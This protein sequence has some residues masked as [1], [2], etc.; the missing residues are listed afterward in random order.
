MLKVGIDAISFYTSHHYLELKTLAEERG[1]DPNKYLTGL[2][3]HKMAIAAP[4]EDIVTLAAN[5]AEAIV[6]KANIAQ[7][8]MVLFATESGIDQS[9]AAGL[10]IHKLLDLSPHCRV[11][12]LK[13][14]CYSGTAGLQLGLGYLQQNPTRKVLLLTADIARYGLH[15]PGESSQ[16]CGAVAMLLSVNPKL[17]TIEPESGFYTQD[18]MDFWR[19]NYC[20]EAFVDGKA[21]SK[22]YLQMLEKT[23]Q[24]Y[25]SHSGKRLSEHEAICFHTP[26]PSL[27][28]RAQ[29]HL[30]KIENSANKH[31]LTRIEQALYY[32]R[33]VGNCYTASLYLSLCSLLETATDDLGTKRVGF[34]SYGSGATAEFF[35]G[36]IQSDY[37]ASLLKNIHSQL[38]AERQQLS[39]AEYK[40]FYNFKLPQDGSSLEVPHF[41][42]G[43]FRLVRIENHKRMYERIGE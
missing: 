1:I 32:N 5:A 15:T 22:L 42:T 8:D 35:S 36:V 26:V 25:A 27:S 16:G 40:N 12:E 4:G 14:A 30:L 39:Y 9:K 6:S 34:Y 33:V 21:S 38:L 43:K 29:K 13:Q 31:F 20:D 11:V 18:N 7:I 19:P 28:E 23:W 41:N 37:Q 2:G 10:Y 24:Q 17:L 3:Q